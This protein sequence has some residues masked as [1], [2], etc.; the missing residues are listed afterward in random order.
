MKEE[1]NRIGVAL[2]KELC[3]ICAKEIEGPI[4]LNTILTPGRAKEVEKLHG[5]VVGYAE[6]PCDECKDL[7]TKGFVLI[8]VVQAKT[9]DMKYPYRSGNI[10]VV[11]HEA[12]TKMF[13]PENL[14]KGVAYIDVLAAELIGLPNPKLNA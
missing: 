7:K 14:V 10:W 8:G 5:K 3:P 12:S 4:I 2:V 11:T 9:D 13:P 1:E 6:K